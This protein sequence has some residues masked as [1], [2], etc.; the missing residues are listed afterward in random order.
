MTDTQIGLGV[1]ISDA[2]R[3]ARA[4]LLFHRGGEWT[5]ED[6]ITWH[7]LTGTDESTTRTLCDLARHVRAAEEH[8]NSG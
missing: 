3:L 1:K 7:A 5:L 8:K 2:E 6:R 4:V